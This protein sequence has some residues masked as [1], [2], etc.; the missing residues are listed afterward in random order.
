MT[1]NHE[2]TDRIADL[3]AELGAVR[4][5]NARLRRL[6][7]EAGMPDSLRHAFRD[8]VARLRSIMR[9]TA[10]SATDV[11]DYHAHLAG[12]LDAIARTRALT[13][14]FGEAEL[15]M[16]VADVLN[17]Y[18]VRVGEQAALDGPDIRL[19]PKA[20]EVFSLAIHELATN[21]VE[22]RGLGSPEG[23]LAVSWR[24]EDG[25]MLI[26]EWT[27]RGPFKPTLVRREGLGMMTLRE[28]LPYELGAQVDLSPGTDGLCCV[29]RFPLTERSGRMAAETEVE[30]HRDQSTSPPRPTV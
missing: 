9:R 21:A 29:I 1:D 7:D 11:E 17:V 3:E 2:A 16:L 22:Q 24:V 18:L 15:H 10:D 19:R 13:D 5:D 23:G 8:T 30:P 6:L 26:L 27:E 20:A 12:Q 14:A 28:A 4:A 25:T